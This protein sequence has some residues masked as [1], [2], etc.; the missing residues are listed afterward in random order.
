MLEAAIQAAQHLFSPGP[1][2]AMLVML[3]IAL[4]S[5]ATPGEIFR[6]QRWFSDLQAIS[7]RGSP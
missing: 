2:L 6:S 1:I 5:G 4:F 7:I 3:P